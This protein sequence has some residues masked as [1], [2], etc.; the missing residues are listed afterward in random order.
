MFYSGMY[1]VAATEGKQV[2]RIGEGFPPREIV[3]FALLGLPG[4]EARHKFQV[5]KICN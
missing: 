4:Q 3:A 1:D 2:R 5:V